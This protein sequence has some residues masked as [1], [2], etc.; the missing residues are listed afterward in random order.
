MSFKSLNLAC[1]PN[2]FWM[3]K[4]ST[5]SAK[6]LLA[7]CTT[8]KRI[9]SKKPVYF[10]ARHL[11]LENILFFTHSLY[12]AHDHELL[13]SL[14]NV[15]LLFVFAGCSAFTCMLL[16][17]QFFLLPTVVLLKF[18]ASSCWGRLKKNSRVVKMNYLKCWL[19]SNWRL[20]LFK[21]GTKQTS[22]HSRW[23]ADSGGLLEESWRK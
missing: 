4:H 15:F 14:L 23:V 2:S 10:S 8:I 7:A 3:V 5:T 6:E 11:V 20:L 13:L 21:W 19:V 16:L 22:P 9:S 17:L 12:L 1:S 18:V